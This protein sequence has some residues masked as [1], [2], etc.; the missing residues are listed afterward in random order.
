MQEGGPMG[1]RVQAAQHFGLGWKT[2]TT[3]THEDIGEIE[4][5]ESTPAML[6]HVLAQQRIKIHTSEFM[7]R[8]AD[9]REQMAHQEGDLAD[10]TLEQAI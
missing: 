7:K 5:A 6:K 1:A 3:W 10:L 4:L 2:A 9:R 8:A